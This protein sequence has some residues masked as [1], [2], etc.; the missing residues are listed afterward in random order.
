MS[1]IKKVSLYGVASLLSLLLI[2]CSSTSVETYSAN[3]PKLV[4]A[5]FF[6]GD[7]IAHGMVKNRGGEVIRYFTADLK[8]SWK[9]GIGTLDESFIFNDG[10]K[11]KRI[12][13]LT[14]HSEK[15]YIATAGDVTGFGHLRTSGNALFMKYVL[16]IPYD[17]SVIEVNVDDRMYLI[18]DSVLLNESLLTKFGFNVGSVSLVILKK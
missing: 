8:A 3:E 4:V 7:L 16:Q 18:E 5:D 12:W 2:S 13:T 9:D 11:Q 17:G 15:G 14:P 1:A 10:E 6:D